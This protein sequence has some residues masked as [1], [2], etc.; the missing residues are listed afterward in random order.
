M[1][2]TVLVCSLA[3]A[4]ALAPNAA[5]P[6]V[7]VAKAPKLGYQVAAAATAFTAPAMALAGGQSEGTGLS[8]GID[9]PRESTVL[10]VIFGFF[11]A[12]YYNWAKTQPDSNS[13]FFAEYDE[14]RSD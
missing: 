11:F 7:Q 2:K 14:R 4:A 9:D 5:R 8:L 12:V 6:K 3:A 10:T 13:D 1:F